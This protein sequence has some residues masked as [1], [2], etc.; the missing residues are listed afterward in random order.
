MRRR[1]TLSRQTAKLRAAANVAPVES[2]FA[3]AGPS[4][5]AGVRMSKP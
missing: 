4:K 3:A 1:G 2:T 5:P